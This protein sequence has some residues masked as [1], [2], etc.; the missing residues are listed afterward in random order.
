MTHVNH[1]PTSTGGSLLMKKSSVKTFAAADFPFLDVDA[2]DTLG[3]IMVT[4]L[5]AQGTLMLGGTP[6]TSVPIAEI[7]V[8]NLG[9]LTYTPASSYT[10]ADSFT[11]QVRDALLF[12]ADA[13]LAITV[14]PDIFVLNGS[15]ET[16]NP[17]TISPGGPWGNLDS[18]WTN[19]VP[20]S[21]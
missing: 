2:G 11:Y 5:P 10:G 18:G 9:S 21:D 3:A 16:P 17:P 15:F 8:A 14:S 19:R 12:S 6:I 7:A 20:G 1:A 4:S 13:T